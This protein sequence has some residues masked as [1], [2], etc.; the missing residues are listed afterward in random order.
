MNVQTQPVTVVV[1]EVRPE[2]V[3]DTVIVEKIVREPSSEG[4]S[5]TSPSSSTPTGNHDIDHPV[6]TTISAEAL[7]DTGSDAIRPDA[8]DTLMDVVRWMKE[9]PGEGIIVEGHTDSVGGREFN[10]NLSLRRAQSVKNFLVSNGARASLISIDVYGY[11][12]PVASNNTPEGR[13]RNRRVE[14]RQW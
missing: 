14:V 8:K 5:T 11:S 3:R 6:I 7:F 13:Q 12:R 2:I 1:P 4:S 9:H 10:L